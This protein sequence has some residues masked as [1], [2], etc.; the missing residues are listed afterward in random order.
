MR[1]PR[2]ASK[3]EE[4]KRALARAS[5]RDFFL[6][7]VRDVSHELDLRTLTGRILQNIAILLQADRSS[8]F[9]VEGPKGK[10]SLVSKVRGLV[11][12]RFCPVKM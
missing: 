9:F 11:I 4:H 2:Y 3:D 5:D 6:E 7:I 10:Q 12:M 8:L 1:L